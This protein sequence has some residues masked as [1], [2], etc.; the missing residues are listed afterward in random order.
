MF[1]AVQFNSLG[2]FFAMGGYAFNVWSV[3]LLFLAFFSINLTFPLLRKKRILREQK[4]RQLLRQESLVAGA[5]AAGS[6]NV[7]GESV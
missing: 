5:G 7:T 3:Y 4:R 2:E 6:V 1:D